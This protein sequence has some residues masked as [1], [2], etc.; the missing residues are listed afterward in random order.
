MPIQWS[1]IRGIIW[2]KQSFITL[3]QGF[4]SDSVYQISSHLQNSPSAKLSLLL[5]LDI[6]GQTTPRKRHS[7]PHH[8]NFQPNHL[9][10]SFT[11]VS[12]KPIYRSLRFPR[13]TAPT[14]PPA[15]KAIFQQ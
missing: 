13:T 11:E 7:T 6:Y 15:F 12:C 9:G 10:G 1:N 3:L 5:K 2:M 14:P 8:S 4:V